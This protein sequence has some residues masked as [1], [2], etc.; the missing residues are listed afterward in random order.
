MKINPS[1]KNIFSKAF[2]DITREF[3]LTL[4]D[5]SAVNTG[6]WWGY[7][8]EKGTRI[9]KEI[10]VVALNNKD[11]SIVFIECKYSLLN[12]KTAF[13]VI[14]DLK[15]K[16]EFVKWHNQQRKEIFGIAAKKIE[17]KEKL[18]EAG[19]IAMDFYDYKK[20]IKNGT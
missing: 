4:P 10:D 17:G 1:F 5:I 9:E 18:R 6:R 3:I 19:Y 12:Y 14:L 7:T 16:S 20:I 15:K 13:R 11:N 8:K 2:E